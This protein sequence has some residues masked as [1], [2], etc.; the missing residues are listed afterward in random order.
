MIEGTEE[1]RRHVIV[2]LAKTWI[3]TPY[4]SGARLRGIG[5]DC[6]QFPAA[7][8]IEAGEVEDFPIESYPHDW[9]L[10]QGAERYLAT[11]FKYARE[12]PKGELP[13]AGDLV[14]WQYGR[15]FSH[16][17]IVVAWPQVLHSWLAT[18]VGFADAELDQLLKM[19]GESGPGQ[20]LER[21]R[22]F[23]TVN[24]GEK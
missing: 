19:K 22:R 8:Y 9:H 15:T 17:G 5:V 3:G 16:G 24:G 20:G 12:L 7:V 23:F 4:S 6:A 10:H 1:Y 18:P 2:S 11:V 13:K 21:K 14:V